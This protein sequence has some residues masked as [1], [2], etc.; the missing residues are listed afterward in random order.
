[1]GDRHFNISPD[2]DR[3]FHPLALS[4]HGYI[5]RLQMQL[6]FECT[7]FKRVG[8]KFDTDAA[9]FQHGIMFIQA[10]TLCEVDQEFTFF[11]PYVHP[12]IAT[13]TGHGFGGVVARR[14]PGNVVSRWKLPEKVDK[15]KS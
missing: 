1:M 13:A 6:L 8:K 7:P 5:S 11:H 3:G 12:D 14:G 4:L 15:L 9:R 10:T 2:A